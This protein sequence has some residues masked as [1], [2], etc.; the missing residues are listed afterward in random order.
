MFVNIVNVNF[1]TT[2]QCSKNHVGQ[3]FKCPICGLNRIA[4]PAGEEWHH[5]GCYC[6]HKYLEMIGGLI[7]GE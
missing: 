3:N 2:Q 7:K 5:T 4:K 1:A 6:T